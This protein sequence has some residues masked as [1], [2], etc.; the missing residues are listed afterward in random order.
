M[1]STEP[2]KPVAEPE[3]H[4]MRTRTLTLLAASVVVLGVVAGVT[5][6][7]A[8]GQD[9]D[10]SIPDSVLVGMPAP[11]IV[12]PSDLAMGHVSLAPGQVLIIST[13]DEGTGWSGKGGSADAAIAHFEDATR[14]DDVSFD[15][16][17]VAGE[18]G[19]TT[20][21]IVDAEGHIT[22]FDITV[23]AS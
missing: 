12:S 19:T 10:S 18:A 9:V 4:L 14:S 6:A 21:Y 11:L 2:P 1:N 7:V 3:R 15:A 13:D 8:A 22:T 16:G 17:F 5:S 23:D 20:A